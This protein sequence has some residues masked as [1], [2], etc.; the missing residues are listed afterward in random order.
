MADKE[1]EDSEGWLHCC[2]GYEKVS[3][4]NSRC[5][6]ITFK[7]LTW[8]DRIAGCSLLPEIWLDE[9]YWDGIGCVYGLC[10]Q[11]WCQCNP[12]PVAS[13]GSFWHHSPWNP[14]YRFREREQEVLICQGS[15]PSSITSS[16]QYCRGAEGLPIGLCYA[17]WFRVPLLQHL[18]GTSCWVKLFDGTRHAI[19]HML[20][21]SSYTSPSWLSRWCHLTAIQ[22]LK[23]ERIWMGKN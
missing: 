18:H 12:D 8:L 3:G 10:L 15:P 23:A 14:W 16:S 9:I 19:I 17:G 7:G 20:V 5:L 22:Y 11:G 13:L 21:T 1:A 2:I 4:A 6:F